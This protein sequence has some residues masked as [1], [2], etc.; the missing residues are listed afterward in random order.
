MGI[1][2]TEKQE[3]RDI[4]NTRVE[5][6]I[7]QIEHENVAGLEAMAEMAR[8]QAIKD[9]ELVEY[10]QRNDDLTATQERL[11]KAQEKL[12]KDTAEKLELKDNWRRE[13]QIEDRIE[14]ATGVVKG[15]MMADNDVGKEILRLQAEQ[16]HMLETVWVATS[17]AQVK[18]LFMKVNSVLNE[19]PTGLGEMAQGIA[20][21]DD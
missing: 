14:K 5:K 9:L 10:V 4:I 8:E 12:Q 20:P 21:T 3:L 6:R 13:E 17:S 16:E 11:K 1:T 18:E 19:S 2:V 7:T 15:K